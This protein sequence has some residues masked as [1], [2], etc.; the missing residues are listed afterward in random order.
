MDP[1]TA[2]LDYMTVDIRKSN[3]SPDAS[4][5]THIGSESNPNRGPRGPRGRRGPPGPAIES[6]IVLLKPEH[7]EYYIRNEA[8][9][10]IITGNSIWPNIY[11]PKIESKEQFDCEY[12]TAYTTRSRLKI[13]N[14]SKSILTIT[15]APGDEFHK[16]G[17]KYQIKSGESALFYGI[18]NQW[19]IDHQAKIYRGG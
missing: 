1:E 15:P 4:S 11:L 10:A 19:Y 17:L 8:D 7:P 5:E 18:D 6:C 3:V 13:M 9:V 2:D 12:L 14:Q 16:N